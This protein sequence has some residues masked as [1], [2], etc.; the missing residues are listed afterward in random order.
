MLDYIKGFINEEKYTNNKQKELSQEI[1]MLKNKMAELEKE[2]QALGRPSWLKC[3]VSPLAQRLSVDL[4]MS[5]DISPLP[6]SNGVVE[7][8]LMRNVGSGTLDTGLISI[9]LIPVDLK[10]GNIHFRINQSLTDDETCHLI[11]KPLL[12]YKDV[13]GAIKERTKIMH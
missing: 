2:Y 5:Y 4:G 11:E 8:Y 7:I 6:N 1:V 10:N 3:I 13:L 12:A 9:S